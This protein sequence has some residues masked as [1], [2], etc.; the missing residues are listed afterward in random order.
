[1]SSRR[2]PREHLR[3]AGTA[4][5][6]SS[7]SL[8]MS[9]RAR[10]QALTAP[11]SYARSIHS[12]AESEGASSPTDH[13]NKKAARQQQPRFSWTK[14]DHDEDETASSGWN[15]EKDQQDGEEASIS[16]G[17][18]IISHATPARYGGHTIRKV[19]GSGGSST[20]SDRRQLLASLKQ[21]TTGRRRRMRRQGQQGR[22]NLVVRRKP[23]RNQR[24][25]IF[26]TSRQPPVGPAAT[27]PTRL[28]PSSTFSR[29][30]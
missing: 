14:D 27:P 25:Q 21:S 30:Q 11:S 4:S 24:R 20:D 2:R 23:T 15:S 12:E 26:D 18:D 3:P 22:I 5:S 7:T 1:M 13:R 16:L 17:S 19:D 28:C 10:R 29:N 8:G 6:S 9:D